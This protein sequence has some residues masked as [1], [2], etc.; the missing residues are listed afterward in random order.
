MFRGYSLEEDL[1]LLINNPNYSDREILCKDEKISY[2]SR[3]I[4]AARSYVFQGLLY[5]GM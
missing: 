1:K 5:N 4:L 2:S 3:V